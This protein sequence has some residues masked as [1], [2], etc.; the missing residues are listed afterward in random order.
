MVFTSNIYNFGTEDQ[1]SFDVRGTITKDDGTE[2]YN[3][4]QEIDGLDSKDNTTLEWTW[5]GGPNGTYTIRVET[6]LDD[7]ERAGNNPKEEAIDIAES[8]YKVALAVEEQ[9]KDVLSGEY[10]FFEFTF[11]GLL[12]KHAE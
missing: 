10:L 4:T 3:E 9:A 8:G 12:T 6:L 5:E 2:F 11:K 1:D 7:D